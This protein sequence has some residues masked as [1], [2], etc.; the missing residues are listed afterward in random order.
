MK[1]L[2]P[3]KVA[4]INGGATGMGRSTALIFAS[5][6]CSC[7]IADINEKDG[8]KT[9]EEATGNGKECIFVKC[10][11]T[12]VKQIKACVDKTVEKFGKVD[13]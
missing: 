13:Y 2:L 6:G 9:A 8:Q 12:D 11:L 10:D 5:E 3:D 4:I 1:P 7:V